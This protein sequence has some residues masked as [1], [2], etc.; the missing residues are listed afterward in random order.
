MPDAVGRFF[1]LDEPNECAPAAD[2]VRRWYGIGS[3]RVNAGHTKDLRIVR[4]WGAT[5]AGTADGFSVGDP[6]E[7]AIGPDPYH[8]ISF[9]SWT[10]EVVPG[11][12]S[13]PIF[14]IANHGGIQ[15]HSVLSIRAGDG[16]LEK[17][18]KVASLTVSPTDGVIRFEGGRR[19]GA[20]R[21][22]GCRW[23]LG[24]GRGLA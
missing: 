17:D 22:D 12:F 10:S 2:T 24:N 21:P 3:V 8:P 16:D 23:P 20:R 18:R 4:H 1:A 15:R 13:S 6:I 19:G 7:Q 14:D 5:S 11:S 9:R